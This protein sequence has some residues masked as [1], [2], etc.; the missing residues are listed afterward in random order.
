MWIHTH[1]SLELFGLLLLD[2]TPSKATTSV[3]GRVVY[4]VLYNSERA[5]KII[6]LSP[7]RDI[8]RRL[9]LHEKAPIYFT[10]KKNVGCHSPV[11][12]SLQIIN[13]ILYHLS[14]ILY[15]MCTNSILRTYYIIILIVIIIIR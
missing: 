13:P 3:K 5:N 2:K 4:N 15:Y 8:R 12:F 6:Y 7:S 11:F 14:S 1:T 9:M 10:R